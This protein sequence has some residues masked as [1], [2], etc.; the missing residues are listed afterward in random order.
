MNLKAKVHIERQKQDAQEK[1]KARLTVL[2]ERRLD[3]KAIER[4]ATLR[5]LKAEVGNANFRL[6]S[7]AAQE[8]LNQERAQAKIDKPAKE[9]A[10]EAAKAEAGKAAAEKKEKKPK[11]EKQ[12]GAEGKAKGGKGKQA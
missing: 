4:D 6:A 3:D 10:K 12:A 1:L 2:K 5:H 11:K 7:I 8:K 9:A